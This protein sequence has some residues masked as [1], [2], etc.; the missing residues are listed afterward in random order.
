MLIQDIEKLG[1]ELHLGAL[2][3]VSIFQKGYV[4]IT[5]ATGAEGIAPQ[6]SGMCLH[7]L[8]LKFTSG[9]PKYV[10][11]LVITS[12]EKYCSFGPCP[13]RFRVGVCKKS[14]LVAPPL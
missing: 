2:S 9:T 8:P 14:G 10:C 12:L 11:Q 7:R 13:P 5:V 1:P 3:D 4:C 6:V